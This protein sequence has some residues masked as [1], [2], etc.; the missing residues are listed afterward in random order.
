MVK[1]YKVKREGPMYVIDVEDPVSF[2]VSWVLGSFP[3]PCLTAVS[4]PSFP[5]PH[6]MLW[7]TIS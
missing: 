1:H 5:A 6:W 4:C 7:S 3:F 2:G